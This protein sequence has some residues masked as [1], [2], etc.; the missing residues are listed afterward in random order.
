MTS[1]GDG[2]RVGPIR[3]TSDTTPTT[4]TTE[5]PSRRDP[6]DAPRN[7]I[8]CEGLPYSDSSECTKADIQIV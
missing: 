6:A 2:R 7:K 8:S 3:A 5:N 4:P 1:S